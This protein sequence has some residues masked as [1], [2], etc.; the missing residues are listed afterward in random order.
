[1]Q[2]PSSSLLQDFERAL[3]LVRQHAQQHD[4]DRAH[5]NQVYDIFKNRYD[6][7]VR[8]TRK[9]LQSMPLSAPEES[10]ELVEL[11]D[12]I[13]S[14]WNW[15]EHL[16]AHTGIHDMQLFEQLMS[17]HASEQIDA[18]IR[19]QARERHQQQ[20]TVAH[21]R[22][23]L[24]AQLRVLSPS[25]P[26]ADPALTLQTKL[27]QQLMSMQ[28]S[29]LPNDEHVLHWQ[30]AYESLLAPSPPTMANV[31]GQV[32]RR[33]PNVEAIEAIYNGIRDRYH[34]WK[35]CNGNLA[36]ELVLHQYIHTLN[37]VLCVAPTTSD[38]AILAACLRMAVRD[39]R[40]P[41]FSFMTRADYLVS[42]QAELLRLIARLSEP[43]RSHVASSEVTHAFQT[44]LV[45]RAL[46]VLRVDSDGD[47]AISSVCLTDPVV[48]GLTQ[49]LDA[50][51]RHPEVATALFF[52]LGNVVMCLAQLE[53]HPQQPQQPTVRD[54]SAYFAE[55][56]T[57]VVL[58]R[59]IPTHHMMLE[60]AHTLFA[61]DEPVSMLMGVKRPDATTTWDPL[62]A[63]TAED[64]SRRLVQLSHRLQS[65]TDAYFRV[66]H[67]QLLAQQ[68]AMSPA[69][70]AVRVDHSDRP[71]NVRVVIATDRF[72]WNSWTRVRPAHTPLDDSDRQAITAL[73]SFVKRRMRETVIPMRHCTFTFSK[74][75]H[76]DQ[77]DDNSHPWISAVTQPSIFAPDILVHCFTPA[78]ATVSIPF[79]V[80]PHTHVIRIALPDADW[81]DF[82]RREPV[83]QSQ[84]D[85]WVCS[86]ASEVS[87]VHRARKRAMKP[88][89]QAEYA[90]HFSVPVARRLVSSAEKIHLPPSTIRMAPRQHAYTLGVHHHDAA[91]PLPQWSEAIVRQ[92]RLRST[93]IDVLVVH[94]ARNT[95]STRSE[96]HLY[97]SNV[98]HD[99]VVRCGARGLSKP[100]TFR[101]RVVMLGS[102][103]LLQSGGDA[104]QRALLPLAGAG[105]SIC[106]WLL[107]CHDVQWALDAYLA[108]RGGGANGSTNAASASWHVRALLHTRPDQPYAFSTVKSTK[109]ISDVQQRGMTAPMHTRGVGRFVETVLYTDQ[110]ARAT[111]DYNLSVLVD[112]WLQQLPT[113]AWMTGLLWRIRPTRAI[114]KVLCG[115]LCV[116][117]ALGS[118][119]VFSASSLAFSEPGN[120]ALPPLSNT[121]QPVL[122]RVT[123]PQSSLIRNVSLALL[124]AL[125]APTPQHMDAEEC[126]LPAGWEAPQHAATAADD[127]G[128]LEWLFKRLQPPTQP[129]AAFDLFGRGTRFHV[130]AGAVTAGAVTAGAVT[131]GAV[132]AAYPAIQSTQTE[133]VDA[134]A[135]AAE[136]AAA[137]A[138]TA[139]SAAATAP[140]AAT[141]TCVLEI[142]PAAN[143]TSSLDTVFTQRALTDLERIHDCVQTV[144]TQAATAGDE[145]MHYVWLGSTASFPPAD[146][147]TSHLNQT[148]TWLDDDFYTTQT[149]RRRRLAAASSS[150]V[151]VT[152]TQS[153]SSSNASSTTLVQPAASEESDRGITSAVFR[154]F[155]VVQTITL[156]ALRYMG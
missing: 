74:H 42:V 102:D 148:T 23:C 62:A 50:M 78:D 41:Q 73:F 29:F 118:A 93:D 16:N 81:L 25:G 49:C 135:R 128:Y 45:R 109:R 36:F 120:L 156:T 125:A 77:D 15:K 132:T 142:L 63:G 140:M 106:I 111:H 61:R 124:P 147:S 28:W 12:S 149:L 24:Q 10:K 75:G 46:A 152:M 138:L 84:L 100:Y 47:A 32:A 54:P 103:V 95:P 110:E 90:I 99:L 144:E 2:G 52:D 13:A 66:S 26:A 76:P 9:H 113:Q 60:M 17:A 5:V 69:L 145:D 48:T 19:E 39:I 80:S 123:Y 27:L 43:G 51:E 131:A 105:H 34:Q 64:A 97:A 154:M 92:G 88:V 150:H 8:Q 7:M 112:F 44:H 38:G 86:K 107:E 155:E 94:V 55:P 59:N 91:L 146:A 33:R 114:R 151:N 68:A 122:A 53:R 141:A 85:R 40:N 56:C 96:A 79:S 37:R 116:G 18:S 101:P 21:L 57:D 143:Q 14:P 89:E 71:I 139:G 126:A 87:N 3:R 67:T 31:H 121:T 104:E 115:A 35:K 133:S 20:A 22:E 11:G 30:S 65:A 153:N 137:T 130:A 72:V 127:T 117:L 70:T 119:G 83:A 6:E 129:L 1:M 134:T 58:S 4:N 82:R 98:A 108:T 136:S